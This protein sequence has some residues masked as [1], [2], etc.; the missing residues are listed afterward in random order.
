MSE[1]KFKT[2]G[3]LE[4]SEGL[5][6]SSNVVIEENGEVKRFPANSIARTADIP[7]DEYINSLIDAKLEVIENGTY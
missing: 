6:E 5:T 3:E 4:I 1:I 2:Y 7:T